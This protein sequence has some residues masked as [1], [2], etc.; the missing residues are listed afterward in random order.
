MF[1]E[2]YFL[3]LLYPFSLLLFKLS[4]KLKL[5]PKYV[6]FSLVG[7]FF[8]VFYGLFS[9][10]IVSR[11]ENS[12]LLITCLIY[13]FALYNDELSLSSLYKHFTLFWISLVSVWG[14]IGFSDAILVLGFYLLLFFSTKRNFSLERMFIW[15]FVIFINLMVSTMG[16]AEG[17]VLKNWLIEIMFFLV[18]ILT[19]PSEG[20]NSGAC[21]GQYILSLGLIHLALDQF[22]ALPYY[23][24]RI[25]IAFQVIYLFTFLKTM[26]ARDLIISVLSCSI[27]IIPSQGLE[28]ILQIGL[29]AYL[30]IFVAKKEIEETSSYLYSFIHFVSII[31]LVYYIFDV[32]QL[33]NIELVS[34]VILLLS[35]I[36]NIFHCEVNIFKERATRFIRG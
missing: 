12:Y 16:V 30:L 15:L 29:S 18:F 23:F 26:K 11:V 7:V 13:C 4:Q 1:S 5:A 3:L 24:T 14:L 27:I 8:F 33:R 21:M 2:Y 6:L 35:L 34:L 20:K 10:F 17:L 28:S 22:G 9:T 31:F 25:L 19:L 36:A 32:N